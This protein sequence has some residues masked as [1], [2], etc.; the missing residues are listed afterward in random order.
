[1]ILLYTCLLLLLVVAKFLVGRRAARLQAR[2]SR[3]VQEVN[4]L[5]AEPLYR[6]GNSRRPD[7]YQTARTQY[8]LGQLI[9]RKDRLEDRYVGWLGRSERLAKWYRAVRHWKGRKL[10]YTFG[11]LDVA[12]ALCLIDYLGVGQVVNLHHLVQLL[13]TWFSA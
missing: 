1:M 4:Q 3:L 12:G 9:Q 8:K 6:E 7:A 2:Y 13:T 10:P 5:A 11:V